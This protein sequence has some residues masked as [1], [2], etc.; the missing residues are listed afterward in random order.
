MLLIYGCDKGISP[1]PE[2][3]GEGFSGTISF[4]GAWPDSI[5]DTR[6]V[7]FDSL[8]IEQNDFNVFNLRYLSLTIPNNIQSFNFTSMDDS[9]L[10][11]IKSG[12]YEYAAVIQSKKS[13]PGLDRSDWFVSGIYYANGD[14]TKP[15]ELIIPKNSFV[16][17][18]NI[19]CDFNNP[20]PQPPSAIRNENLPNGRQ[21]KN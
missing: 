21:V 12:D 18:I 5:T 17:D 19:I 14:T 13:S 11:P 1:E 6:L 9:S 7:V 15:G 10:V 20:P 3:L 2:N 4:I 16:K 8:L